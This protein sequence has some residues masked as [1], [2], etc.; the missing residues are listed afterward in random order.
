MQDSKGGTRGYTYN[1]VN[2]VTSLVYSDSGAALRADFTYS[3]RDQ[4]TQID[5][6]T[7]TA[8]TQKKSLTQF[9]YDDAGK[10]TSI[11]HKDG[12]G[13]TTINVSTNGQ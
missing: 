10:T 8:G 13:T 4:V 3:N 7:D 12:P 9:G 6:F 5:R 1:N 2:L 11:T